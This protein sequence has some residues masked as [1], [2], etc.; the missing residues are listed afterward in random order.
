M[1]KISKL[2][3]SAAGVCAVVLGFSSPA[4]ADYGPSATDIVGVGSDTVQNLANFVADGDNLGDTGYNAADNPDKWVSFDATPDANDRAGYL[5]GSTS[6]TP[7]P[8]TPTIVLRAGTSP[9]QRPNGS[10]DGIAALLLDKISLTNPSYQINYVRSSKLPAQA[11][12]NTAATNGW[13]YLHVIQVSTD[14]LEIAYNGTTAG[15][16]AVTGS[17][18]NIPAAGLSAQ[19]LVS[20]YKGTITVW[21][22]LPGC[23]VSTCSGDNIIPLIPQPGSGTGKTFLADLKAANGNVDI[24]G[25]LGSDVRV[26]EENDP[27]S[28]TGLGASANDAIVPFS[29]SRLRLW[30]SH[31]FNSSTVKYGNLKVPLSPGISIFHGCTTAGDLDCEIHPTTVTHA[32]AADTNN[33]YDDVRGLY[34]IFRNSD[35]IPNVNAPAGFNGTTHNWVQTLLLGSGSYLDQ[36]STQALIAAAGATPNYQDLTST[37]SG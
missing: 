14:P 21:N 4:F 29:L 18:S 19:E 34:Y 37:N 16:P 36:F 20:I 26:V 25:A 17:T 22:Q 33:V 7:I 24:T 11:D 3:V 31:Y 2:S 23:T 27:T 15:G 12:D 10:G 13:G 30:N 6:V 5:E 28:I 9:V 8:L 32:H 35:S 1:R